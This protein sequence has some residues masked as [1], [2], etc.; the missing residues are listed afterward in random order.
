MPHDLKVLGLSPTLSSMLGVEPAYYSARRRAF[1]CPGCLTEQHRKLRLLTPA[2]C[3]RGF[4]REGCAS[5]PRGDLLLR[6]N[7]LRLPGCRELARAF[8]GGGLLSQEE[9]QTSGRLRVLSIRDH[10]QGQKGTSALE[11]SPEK[12][13]EL[14]DARRATS[15]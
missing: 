12:S 10:V 1:T 9:G 15:C 14:T 4:R 5:L 7:A 3:S 11:A 2:E 6:M 8:R 13:A